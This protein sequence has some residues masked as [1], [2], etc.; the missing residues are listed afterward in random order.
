MGGV[1]LKN[2]PHSGLRSAPV[3]ALI[4]CHWHTAPVPGREI[5]GI[6][7]WA[8]SRVNSP[9][10]LALTES[11]LPARSVLFACHRH[12]APPS[13]RGPCLPLR[14]RRVPVAHKQGTDRAGRRECPPHRRL[15]GPGDIPLKKG[16]LGEG[17]LLSNSPRHAIACH[18]LRC[19]SGRR[20]DCV[21][22]AHG[23]L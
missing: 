5:A 14:G 21:P 6:Y 23:A 17:G 4:V 8:Y 16:C 13:E 15:R 12:A 22:L 1:F 10:Q 11:R 9:S 19:R 2:A 18:L 20:P 3:G 7:E